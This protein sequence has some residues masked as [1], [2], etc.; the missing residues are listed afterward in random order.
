MHFF[1]QQE[2]S[3]LTARPCWLE[4]YG[5]DFV[6]LLWRCLVARCH[7]VWLGLLVE[8]KAR[9][10]VA[11]AAL[12]IQAHFLITSRPGPYTGEEKQDI[13]FFVNIA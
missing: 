4:H 7:R 5:S 12:L 2:M 3:L 9:W 1:L 8:L 11:Q 6:L 13:D 10:G